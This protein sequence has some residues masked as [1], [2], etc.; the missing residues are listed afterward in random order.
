[1]IGLR[2]RVAQRSYFRSTQFD[3]LQLF[4]QS[5][6]MRYTGLL[7][8]LFADFASLD[9]AT[10]HRSFI[11]VPLIQE[12]GQRPRCDTDLR[13]TAAHCLAPEAIRLYWR[14][15]TLAFITSPAAR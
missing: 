4:G 9:I 7:K 15:F 8:Q 10:I 2:S 6:F 11:P 1:M 13:L 3:K 14:S 5:G 12:C